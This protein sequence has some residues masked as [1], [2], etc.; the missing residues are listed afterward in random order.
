MLGGGNSNDN[1]NG[2]RGDCD[3]YSSVDCGGSS[4]VKGCGDGVGSIV[5]KELRSRK[6]MQP[7]LSLFLIFVD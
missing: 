5:T 1:G 6:H 4:S 2:S 3:E 7:L